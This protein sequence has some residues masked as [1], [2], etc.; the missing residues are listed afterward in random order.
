MNSYERMIQRLQGEPVDRP[1]NFDIMMTFA[2]HYVGRPLSRYYLDH[3]VLAGVTMY[4]GFDFLGTKKAS[5]GKDH[6]PLPWG[7]EVGVG[8]DAEGFQD[9]LDTNEDIRGGPSCGCTE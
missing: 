1:P 4:W 7:L 6:V 3:R 2:A 8:G 5:V 9:L